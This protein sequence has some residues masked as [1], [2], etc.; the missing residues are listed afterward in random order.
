MFE[1]VGCHP[2]ILT[3]AEFVKPIQLDDQISLRDLESSNKGPGVLDLVHVEINHPF[4]RMDICGFIIDVIPTG[5]IAQAADLMDPAGAD[6]E[7]SAVKFVLFRSVNPHI[8]PRLGAWTRRSGFLNGGFFGL[9][10]RDQ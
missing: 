4:H 2:S 9:S 5:R 3:G 7:M 8:C 6:S 1:N 10:T